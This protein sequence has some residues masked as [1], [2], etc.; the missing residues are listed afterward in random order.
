MQEIP[1]LSPDDIRTARK[2]LGLSQR[3]F[4][5]AFGISR[6][7]VENWESEQSQPTPD[8]VVRLALAALI[9]GLEPYGAEAAAPPQSTE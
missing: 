6:R 4:A 9:A 5:Y 3:A 7:T 2:A 1:P 8:R